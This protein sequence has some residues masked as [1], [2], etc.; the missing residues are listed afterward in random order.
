MKMSKLLLKILAV[1]ALATAL[2]IPS[3]FSWYNHNGSQTGDSMKYTREK[4]PVSA[5]TVTIETKK[6]YTV[7]N[8]LWYDT[9]GNKKYDPDDPDPITSESSL[10]SRSVAA[11]SV[12]YYGTTITN[13]GSA[14]AYVNLYLR[15]FT[16][17]PTVKI[18]TLQPSLTHKG[19]SSSVHLKNENKVRIYCQFGN[20]NNWNDNSAKRYLV[21]KTKTGTTQ[22]VE[23]T[24]HI[25][26]GA[27]GS[28]L[29][30]TQTQILGENIAN[31][32]YV[33][34]PGNATEFYFATDG[35]NSGFDTT[36]NTVTMP[37]YRTKTITNIHAETGYY[38]TGV[39]DD[40][41]WN[42]QYGTFNIPGGVSVKTYFDTATINKNQHAYVTLNKGT[43]YTGASAT[44]AV[45]SYGEAN[46]PDYIPVNDS[47]T[48]NGNTGYVTAKDSLGQGNNIAYIETEITGSLGDKT[49]VGTFISN[50]DKIAGVPVALNVE[51]PG[52]TTNEDNEEVNGTAEIVWYIDNSATSS[53]V[54]FNAIY[55]TK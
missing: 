39:A 50:P 5:G 15:N 3:T 31:T 55:Y 46:D 1:L 37:W 44:Y 32:Y 12:Q 29:K 26:A 52:K 4:L 9:K 34:L 41:T 30:T 11:S 51:V 40:T 7:N 24:S 6:Y 16:N 36:N 18:G 8:K 20:A 53:Q 54:Q 35:K 19:L 48:V 43:N 28:D 14:P 13:T 33:D 27:D 49:S 45:A 17:S 2:L 10:Q 42:A 22:N 38:L 23:I 21:Y 25:T 47:I